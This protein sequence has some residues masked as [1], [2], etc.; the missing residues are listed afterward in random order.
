MPVDV[1]V[2]AISNADERDV[3]SF[4]FPSHLDHLL[5]SAIPRDFILQRGYR[6]VTDRRQLEALGFRKQQCRV[7]GILIP[8]HGVNGDGIVGY[9]FRPD[10]PRPN[11][12]GKPIKY[13]TPT[14]TTNRIDCPPSCRDGL[15]NPR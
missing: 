5:Q 11:N 2:A 12:R 1:T 7:P 10:S 14:G 15:A 13:E 6:T 3:D 8:L 4:L 9:Q